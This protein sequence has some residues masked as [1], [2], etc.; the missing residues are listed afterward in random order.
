MNNLDRA[1]SNNFKVFSALP[2]VLCVLFIFLVLAFTFSQPKSSGSM[3]LALNMLSL[4]GVKLRL[5]N[6]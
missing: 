3:S 2:S 5:I 6:P 1:T 4:A